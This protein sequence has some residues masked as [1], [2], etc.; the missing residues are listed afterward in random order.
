MKAIQPIV[1]GHGETAAV[2][3]LLRRLQA[4]AAASGFRI[5]RPIRRKRP[6]LVARDSLQKSVKLALLQ[7]DAEAILVVFDADDDCPREL[8]PTLAAWAKEVATEI[9]VAIVMAKREYEAWLLAAVESFRGRAGILATAMSPDDPESVRGAKEALEQ[10]MAAGLGYSPST[11]Q[12][13]LTAHMDMSLAYRRSRSFRHLVSDFGL[14][15]SSLTTPISPWPPA[16]WTTGHENGGPMT[17]H[18]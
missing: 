3:E 9:P 15:V 16:A 8:A 4:E 18:S 12:V 11:D 6:E 14:L 5:G 2:P 10:R 7:P 1:E 17:G 13:A